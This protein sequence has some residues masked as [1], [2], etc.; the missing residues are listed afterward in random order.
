MQ[1]P[2]LASVLIAQSSCYVNNTVDIGS[3]VANSTGRAAARLTVQQGNIEEQRTESK[4]QKVA[5]ATWL[6]V[7]SVF[8]VL[9]IIIGA[10]YIDGECHGI[11]LLPYYLLVTGVLALAPAAI[12][13]T[14]SCSQTQSRNLEDMWSCAGK[15]LFMSVILG[16]A[17]TFYILTTTVR[18][19]NLD[20]LCKQTWVPIFGLVVV[21]ADWALF[22]LFLRLFWPSEDSF[23]PQ[24]PDTLHPFY[25]GFHSSPF[26]VWKLRNTRRTL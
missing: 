25:P 12:A 11:C 22:L 8:A 23:E 13:V 1:R 16:V 2:Q 20:R 3:T 9:K 5:V 4:M 10:L 26:H 7:V 6:S 21:V 19:S 17:G 18:A 15:F 14:V 24:Y